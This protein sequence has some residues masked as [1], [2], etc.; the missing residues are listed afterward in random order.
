MEEKSQFFFEKGRN[1]AELVQ[2]PYC[3]KIGF[4]FKTEFIN[5]GKI[6]TISLEDVT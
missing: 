4:C 1:E 3:F 2:C 5:P 6:N